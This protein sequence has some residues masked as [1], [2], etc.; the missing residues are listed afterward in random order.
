MKKLSDEEFWKLFIKCDNCGYYNKL[1][2]IKKTGVCH[3]CNK[4]LDKKAKLKNEI[5]KRSKKNGIKFV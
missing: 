3:C 1:N 2:Y 4:I 5:I